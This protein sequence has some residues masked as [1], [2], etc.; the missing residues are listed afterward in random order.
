MT[1]QAGAEVDHGVSLAGALFSYGGLS[2]GGIDYYCDDV[3]NIGY[4]EGKLLLPLPR[5][6]GVLFSTQYIDQRTVGRHLQTDS[7]YNTG[8]FAIRGE[9]SYAGAVF[10]LAWSRTTRGADLVNP[11]SG[12]PGYTGAMIQKFARAGEHALLTKISYDFSQLGITGL[13]AYALFAH[14]R[15]RVQPDTD[16]RVPNENEVD[17]DL[18]WRPTWKGLSGLWLRARYGHVEQY[19]GPKNAMTE[20]RVV[21]NYDFSLL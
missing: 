14:G 16:T 19:Q 13:T 11:W 8:L 17:L 1:R 20:L 10:T 12:N 4:A 7:A 3:L 2:V 5:E 18:Q 6:A 15:S 21:V 9:T